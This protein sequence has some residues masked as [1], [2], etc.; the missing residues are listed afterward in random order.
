MKTD[1]SLAE[2]TQR[3]HAMYFR[4]NRCATDAATRAERRTDSPVRLTTTH[5]QPRRA[6]AIL[7][8]TLLGLVLS[9]GSISVNAAPMYMVTDLGM[10]SY[11]TGINNSGQIVGQSGWLA[12]QNPGKA[13]IFSNTG[14]SNTN[15][16]TLGGPYGIAYGIGDNGQVFGYS[17]TNGELAHATLF[18]GTGSGNT[19]LGTLGGLVSVA[20]G[21]GSTGGSTGTAV[22]YAYTAGN[23]QFHATLFSGT[24]IGNT[25]LGTLGGTYSQATA[26]NDNGQV[27][28]FANVAGNSTG[29]A[30]LFDRTGNGSNVNLGTL[31]GNRSYATSINNNGQVVGHAF[32][33]SNIDH[34]TLFDITGNGGN[35]DLG[36]LGGTLSL[37]LDINNNGQVVGRAH[38]A[39]EQFDAFLWAN[40]LMTALDSLIDPLAG[41]DLIEAIGIND[42][43]QIAAYGLDNQGQGHALILTLIPVAANGVPEPGSLA[44]IGVA[45]LGL[46]LA[47][48]RRA[49]RAGAASLV[50][51]LA[52]PAHAAVSVS[53]WAGGGTSGTDAFDVSQG[54][55]VVSSTAP[56]AGADMRSAIGFVNP[57]TFTTEPDTA[58]FSDANAAGFVDSFVFK[59]IAPVTVAGFELRT[60][61]DSYAGVGNA[62][63]AFSAVTLSGSSDGTNFSVL[64]SGNLGNSY[65]AAY[66]QSGIL[67]AASFSPVTAQFFRFE[68]VQAT[69]AG[70]RIVELDAIPAALPVPE[71]AS[72]AMLLAGLLLLGSFAKRRAARA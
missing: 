65:T 16:G 67:I 38:N 46:A 71:P 29:F 6:A 14:G 64:A 51:L 70:G 72:Y 39:S 59:T 8:S 13:S 40:G 43:G 47:R 30:T 28:G 20:L 63:R 41:F 61:D 7:Y 56:I 3:P 5:R 4:G 35:V 22:G 69:F 34:A 48:K 24:G 15:L 26:V 50:L 54:T 62:N 49:I 27:V 55:V 33:A 53:P 21:F 58:Y 2:N 42:L 9:S 1:Q 45:L 23:T 11:A 52:W 10:N 60:Y 19:D 18:S 31:G 37:A 12:G 32:T 36:T 25:D 68:G 57:A 66:G 17:A 44:L